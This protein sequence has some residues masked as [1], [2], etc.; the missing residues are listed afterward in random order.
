MPRVVRRV[1]A[2]SLMTGND[3]VMPLGFE[4]GP[5]LKSDGQCIYFRIYDLD[6]AFI[7]CAV[8][9]DYL[10]LRAETDGFR[11]QNSGALFVLYKTDIMRLASELFDSGENRPMITPS[12]L[13]PDFCSQK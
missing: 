6:G 9:V 8:S 12:H 10:L 13:S 4:D 5:G 7:E 11:N 1:R 2:P 3:G